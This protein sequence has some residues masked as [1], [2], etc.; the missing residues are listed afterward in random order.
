MQFGTIR[1]RYEEIERKFERD[2]NHWNANSNHSKEIREG[3]NCKFEPFKWATE[4]KFKPFERDSKE[5]NANSNHSK[6]IL[7][8]VMQIRAIRKGC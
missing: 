8:I 6:G 4:C 5:S 3:I 1:T 7:T 2:S